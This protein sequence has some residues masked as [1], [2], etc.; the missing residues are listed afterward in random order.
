MCLRESNNAMSPR[1][2][3]G[4]PDRTMRIAVGLIVLPITALAFIGAKTPL[5]YLGLVGIV[6]LIAGITG[7]CLPY[8]LPGINTYKGNKSKR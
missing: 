3:L 5:A 4:V 7:Y 1:K 6:P 2:N 8:R